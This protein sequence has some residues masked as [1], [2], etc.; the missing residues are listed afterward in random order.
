MAF[1]PVLLEQPAVL[2]MPPWTIKL[3]EEKSDMLVWLSKVVLA[4]NVF[5]VF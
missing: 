3:D 1:S 4:R 5:V 2:S